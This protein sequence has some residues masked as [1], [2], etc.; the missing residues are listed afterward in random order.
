MR[1]RFPLAGRRDRVST[2]PPARATAGGW[3]S[4]PP[5]PTSSSRPTSPGS[6][7][8]RSRPRFPF[9]D[10]PLPPAWRDQGSARACEVR[11]IG[12]REALAPRAFRRRSPDQLPTATSSR[13]PSSHRRADVE[14]V[15]LYLRQRDTDAAGEPADPARRARRP[16]FPPPRPPHQSR[17]MFAGG[18]RGRRAARSSNGSIVGSTTRCRASSDSGSA[19]RPRATSIVRGPR[20]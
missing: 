16:G 3:R 9:A 6:V 7:C 15:T 18:R 11:R 5:T 10:E 20:R 2:S 1:S 4:T 12:V 17:I 19:G 14:G 8:S 13:A